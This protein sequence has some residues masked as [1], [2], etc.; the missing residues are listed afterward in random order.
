VLPPDLF[1]D[2]PVQT[3]KRV[4]LEPLTEAVLD[5]YLAMLADPELGRLNFR[6]ALAGH[7]SPLTFGQPGEP[8]VHRNFRSGV[9]SRPLATMFQTL[10]S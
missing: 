7:R 3:G 5:D 2:Q 10:V 9:P 4:R 8:T 1:R 6:I